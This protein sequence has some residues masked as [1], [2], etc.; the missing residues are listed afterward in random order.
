[1]WVLSFS[2]KLVLHTQLT[3]DKLAITLSAVSRYLICV[4]ANS[5]YFIRYSNLN[6]YRICIAF[7]CLCHDE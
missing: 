5:I 3:S 2:I 4:N 1:M 6:N 7:D